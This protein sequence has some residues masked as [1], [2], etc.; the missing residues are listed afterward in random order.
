MRNGLKLLFV[1][2]ALSVLATVLIMAPWKIGLMLARIEDQK[3]RDEIF[4]YVLE[5]KP[6]YCCC[7]VI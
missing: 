3:I 5:N 1:D 4:E 7:C 6:S 2:F